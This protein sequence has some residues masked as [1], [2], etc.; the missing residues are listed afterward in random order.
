MEDGHAQRFL[1]SRQNRWLALR[2][3]APET[4]LALCCAR[5]LVKVN[6]S[7]AVCY[8]PCPSAA[9]QVVLISNLPHPCGLIKVRQQRRNS[10]KQYH[11]HTCSLATRA[12]NKN[13]Q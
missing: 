2:L 6:E 11:A 5:G 13:I 9:H 1:A 7:C 4:L 12:T 3:P 10:G 8:P